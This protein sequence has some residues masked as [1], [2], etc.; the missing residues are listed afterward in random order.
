MADVCITTADVYI[1]MTV[2]RDVYK[3]YNVESVNNVLRS[4]LDSLLG[5]LSI[6]ALV[7]SDEEVSI[8]T[9]DH[10]IELEQFPSMN[11][12]LVDVTTDESMGELQIL[13]QVSTNCCEY[14][15]P[16]LTLST[17]NHNY[18]L[19]PVDKLDAFRKMVFHTS[20]LIIT[21]L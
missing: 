17:Y 18:I 14:N 6:F 8:I 5:Q 10:S 16:I 2:Q 12:Y 9:K 3:V 20:N 4:I 19:F 13:K 1:T 15:I 7:R 11:Y 21:Y